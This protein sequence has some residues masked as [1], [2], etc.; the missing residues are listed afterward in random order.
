MIHIACNIDNNYVRHCAVMLVSLFENNAD[1]K[2]TVHVV[3]NG[4]TPVDR[5]LLIDLAARYGNEACFY[6]VSPQ[7]LEGFTIR[8]S[9]GRISLAAY[10]RCLLSDILPKNIGRVLYLD[11]DIVVRGSIRRLWDT[12]LAGKSAV[13]VEDMGCDEDER[14][15]IL[16]YPKRYSYFNSGVMLINLG[17]WRSHQMA[18]L[19][20]DYYHTY[21]ERI[22]FNDQDV[23]NGVMYKDKLLTD[24]C[25]NV[26]DGFYRNPPELSDAWKRKF[27]AVLKDP[28]ILH[29][30]NRKPWDYDSQHP[31]R[32]EYFRYLDLTPWKGWRP[33][34]HL[35]QKLKRFFRL[36]PF[37]VGL[38]RQKYVDLQKL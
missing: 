21:P 24:L 7:S 6:K 27:A 33:T 2:M 34:Q 32:D 14:Y 19:C 10:Y 29:F 28:V 18:Q 15:R 9:H 26:Q 25:W 37:Y 31:L 36:L 30:T 5:K 17:Y 38:R 11:C 1:E 4:L 12:P 23:L 22:R 16:Q 35:G 3:E 20:K 8:M 13:V